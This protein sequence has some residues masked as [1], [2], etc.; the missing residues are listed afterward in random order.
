MADRLNVLIAS[1]LE[2]AHVAEIRRR[3]PSVEVVYRPEFLGTP[4]YVADHT[5]PT[6][7]TP[8]QEA[9]WRRLLGQADVLFDFDFANVD[10][11]ATLA[12]RVKWIQTSSA[13]IGQLVK[14]A[15]LIDTEIIFTTASGIHRTALA[16]FCIMAM[17]MFTKQA[18]H[19]ATE[20]Q[21]KQWARYCAT[22]LAGQTLAVIGLGRVGRHVAKLGQAM[23]LRVIG[24]KRT[25]AGVDPAALHVDALYPTTALHEVLGQADFVVL[26]TP[27]TAET[28][29]LIGAAE[30][31]QMKPS[32]VLINIAR[33]VVV[34]EPALIDALQQ[35]TIAGAALD[36][37]ATEPLPPDNP[38]WDLPN[39][40]ISPHSA[41]TT[42]NENAKLTELF[43]TNLERY[44]AGAPMENVLNRNLLY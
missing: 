25:I 36:V 32:A 13:G 42:E 9:E 30:L 8:E 21:R 24:I 18:F 37:F 3:V 4:R 26:I 16:E 19:L 22:E 44:L 6:N 35:R 15:G 5:T 20:K 41:S 34:D 2:P 14:R 31:A 29:E 33:G 10:Q 12:P 39:V 28:E 11:L 38:L 23:G 40:L 43:I 27:H 7:R 1:Y 17:L